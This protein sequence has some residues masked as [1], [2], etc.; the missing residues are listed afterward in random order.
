MVPLLKETNT[1]YEIVRQ[2]TFPTLASKIN[3][4]TKRGD[5]T[6]SFHLNASSSPQS[7]GS[8]V[9]YYH[10]SRKGK[11]LAEVFQKAILNALGTKD[12]NICPRCKSD[13]GGSL[14][15]NT[16]EP[17]VIL[18][19][20]FITNENEIKLISERRKELAIAYTYAIKEY[21]AYLEEAL[22]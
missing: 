19:P 10:T 20:V 3:K 14:L 18:E 17:C 22:K 2:D 21:F 6:I 7:N 11:K 13:R 5:F 15:F 4:V 8:E 9:L 12:R 16:K 1:E